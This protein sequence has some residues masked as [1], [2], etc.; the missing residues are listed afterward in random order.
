MPADIDADRCMHKVQFILS[1]K[2]VD[3]PPGEKNVSELVT[4]ALRI[5]CCIA[6]SITTVIHELKKNQST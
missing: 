5:A 4:A 2:F 6:I 1:S 3:Q